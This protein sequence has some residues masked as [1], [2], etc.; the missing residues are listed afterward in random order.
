MLGMISATA[1]AIENEFLLK[2]IHMQLIRQSEERKNILDA[3]TDGIIYIDDSNIITQVNQEMAKMTGLDRDDMI[4]RNIN[5]IQTTPKINAIISSALQGE[6]IGKTKIIGKK[7]SYNCLVSY[8]FTMNQETRE[9]SRV[10][11][12]IRYDEIQELAD[13]MSQ[14]NRAFFTFD[15]IIGKSD[16]LTEAIDLAQKAAEHNVRVIIEGESGTGK[17]MFAQAIHNCG[18]REK[19]PFVAVDCGAIPRELLESELFGYEEGAYTGARKGGH[20]GKFEIAHTGTLFLDEIINLP[21]DMQSKLLRVLQENKILRIGGYRPIPV[22]VQVI[23]ATNR[24]LHH[25]VENGNFRE[26]LFYRLNTVCIKLPALRERKEDIVTLVHFLIQR[27]KNQFQHKIKGIDD[28]AMAVLMSYD[29]PGNVRQLSNVVDRMML[30]AESDVLTENLIP[31][32]IRKAVSEPL[33]RSYFSDE[34]EPLD[35]ATAKYIKRA[36]EACNGNIK[37]TAD[38]LNISRATIY[39]ALKKQE[40]NERK[41]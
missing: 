26:D 20:R 13:R 18:N 15:D 24:D 17:E 5:I 4:G 1:K 19:N 10:L 31:M 37:K 16:E 36:R 27:N 3:V 6:D 38:L 14:E 34:F 23:A 39:R 21:V 28:G 12:F 11:F 33:P 35:V 32:E 22:D 7:K 29:W 25:E 8:R 2:E 41:E 9:T 30:V 40:E